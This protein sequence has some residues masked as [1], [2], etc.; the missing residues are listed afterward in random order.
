VLAEAG[1]TGAGLPNVDLALAALL[2]VGGLPL[3]APVLAI[4]RI[5]G[6]AA[7]H[8]EEVGE[9]PLRYRGLTRPRP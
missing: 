7:H 5:A 8:A 3:D 2:V 1:R 6:W 4:A 9:H